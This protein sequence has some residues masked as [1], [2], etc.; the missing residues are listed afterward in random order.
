MLVALVC[1]WLNPHLMHWF[2]LSKPDYNRFVAPVVEEFCKAIFPLYL[3]SRSKIGFMV[4]AAIYGFTIG[5]GFA[6]FENIYFLLE[7]N[8]PNLFLWIIRGFGTAL[9]H[10]GTISILLIIAKFLSEKRQRSP[11]LDMFPGFLVAVLIHA[12]FNQFWFPPL[13]TTLGQLLLLPILIVLTF[14]RSE[15][16][17]RD[18]LEV[19]LDTDLKLLEYIKSGNTQET[20]AGQYLYSLKTK[21]PG[22]IVADMLCYLRLHLELAIR[23]KGLLL[24]QEAGIS[25]PPD[26]DIKAKFTE[27]KFLA[28][29]IGKTGQLAMAPI[30]HNSARD[31]WQLFILDRK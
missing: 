11:L 18:W 12:F 16:N 19:G 17:L 10:G 6:F 15:D 26:P 23:A 14:T 30:L 21:F 20:K 7:L 1:L 29:S 31:L 13:F 25:A 24:M 28:Q 4:D 8:D 5:T 22:E 2:S 9:M 27:L 3:L